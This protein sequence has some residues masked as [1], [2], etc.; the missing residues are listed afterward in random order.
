MRITAVIM[1]LLTTRFVTGLD[2]R[3]QQAATSPRVTG[4]AH[5]QSVQGGELVSH[6]SRCLALIAPA[7][8]VAV[9]G[10][11]AMGRRF[12]STETVHALTVEAPALGAPAPVVAVLI[13]RAV[14]GDTLASDGL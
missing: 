6:L 4:I 3:A 14:H 11:R 7:P 1:N 10:F 5:S 13:E 2:I 9:C 8:V 12:S